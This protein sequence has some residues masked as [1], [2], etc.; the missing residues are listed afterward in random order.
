MANDQFADINTYLVVPFDEKN[1]A[2]NTV[3]KLPNGANAITF[4]G[5]NKLWYAKPSSDLSK[6]AQWMPEPEPEPSWTSA[7]A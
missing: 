7:A 4:D 5:D 2:V 3:G 1:D 6:I